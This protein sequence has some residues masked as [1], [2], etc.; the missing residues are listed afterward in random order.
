MI[1][2]VVWLLSGCAL[3]LGCFF[4]LSGAVGLL[5][6]PDFY[7]RMHAAGVTD[8]LATFLILGGLMLLAGWSLAL[9]K[10]GMILLFLFFTGPVASH[11][12]ARAAQH[13]EWKLPALKTRGEQG[14]ATEPPT[15]AA[16]VAEADA[17]NTDRV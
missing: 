13:S 5:R 4:M 12:L 16:D 1:E 2:Q 17:L 3:A 9:F 8:T 14:G 11:A 15:A 7:T 6:F 10:L